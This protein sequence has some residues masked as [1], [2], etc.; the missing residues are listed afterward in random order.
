MRHKERMQ[1]D[2]EYRLKCKTAEKRRHKARMADPV[3]RKR[4]QRKDSLR[5]NFGISIDDYAI[6]Q[7]SQDNKCGICGL[8]PKSDER[9]LAVD[10]DHE[11]DYIRGLLCFSC[12]VGIGHLKDDERLLRRAIEWVQRGK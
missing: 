2:P 12:N 7:E 5:H 10:H 4:E 1:T 11:T 3:Y 8:E 6:L 9:A